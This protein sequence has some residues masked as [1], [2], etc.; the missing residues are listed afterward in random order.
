MRGI[1]AALAEQTDDP[2]KEPGRRVISSIGVEPGR[3]SR[4]AGGRRALR[5]PTHKWASAPHCRLHVDI[6]QHVAAVR[7]GELEEF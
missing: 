4:Q 5:K 2:L 3:H 1:L 7:N 6:M